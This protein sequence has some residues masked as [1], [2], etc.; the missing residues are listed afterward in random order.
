MKH[1]KIEAGTVPGHQVGAE[2]IQ[3]VKKPAH[4]F[5]LVCILVTKRP[6]SQPVP[7]P[8]KTGNRHDPMLMQGQ[9]IR[10]RRLKALAVHD[11]RD[12]VVVE[13]FETIV[14]PT[15]IKVRNCLDVKNQGV[16]CVISRR[17]CDER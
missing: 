3:A 12:L 2:L 6:D 9:E 17:I 10:A 8:Q 13:A 11:P 4:Q 7:A 16:D 1:R 14:A 5:C 15:E